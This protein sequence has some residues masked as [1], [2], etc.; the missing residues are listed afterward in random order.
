MTM[1]VLMALTAIA[2]TY[3]T[4][5]MRG[6]TVG[7]L[8]LALGSAF[9]FALTL[10]PKDTWVLKLGSY[11][12]E[13]ALS[14]TPLQQFIST[15]RSKEFENT[16]CANYDMQECQSVT[17]IGNTYREAFSLL[18]WLCPTKTHSWNSLLQSQTQELFLKSVIDEA[19][20]TLRSIWENR[21][22]GEQS[23]KQRGSAAAIELLS[24]PIYSDKQAVFKEMLDVMRKELQDPQATVDMIFAR[25]LATTDP[26]RAA[27]VREALGEQ[28]SKS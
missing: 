24:A 20:D 25:G 22:S 26:T 19:W 2:L 27:M 21:N 14:L 17:T 11:A 10:K 12:L 5:G 7:F 15:Q 16:T 4:W 23:D 9:Q 3:W 1:W 13:E 28:E 18:S 8:L 6:W